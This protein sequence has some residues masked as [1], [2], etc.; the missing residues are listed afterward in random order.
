MAPFKSSSFLLLAVVTVT[1]YVSTTGPPYQWFVSQ[2][3]CSSSVSSFSRKSPSFV[4][5]QNRQ[6]SPPGSRLLLQEG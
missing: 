4:T 6:K 1:R 3:R 5:L 2:T